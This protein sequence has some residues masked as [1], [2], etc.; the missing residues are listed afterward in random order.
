MLV[1]TGG[2]GKTSLSTRFVSGE[3]VEE[4]YA[5]CDTWKK[6]F[7]IQ[8]V[9][10][11]M[12]IVDHAGQR[13]YEQL[14]QSYVMQSKGF[15]CVFSVDSVSS[16][17]QASD[18]IKYIQQIKH[19]FVVPIVLVGSKSDLETRKVSFAEAQSVANLFNCIRYVEVSAKNNINVEIP[20]YLLAHEL[21][22]L[23]R[24]TTKKPNTK[25]IK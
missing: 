16:L 12:I 5:I 21:L 11:S 4:E 20:F 6:D 14:R 13:E 15:L 1:G 25:L 19:P 2:V 3:Y 22:G 23:P 7:E 9:S 17:T 8:G 24:L 10:C 18:L